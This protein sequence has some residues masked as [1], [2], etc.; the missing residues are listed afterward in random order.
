MTDAL[1]DELL[2]PLHGQFASARAAYQAYLGEGRTFFH[3]RR[4]KRINLSTRALLAEKGDMLPESLQ[5][6]AAALIEHYDV[7]LTLWDELADRTRPAPGDRFVFENK[8]TY[9]REAE[10]RLER[11]YEALRGTGA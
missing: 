10:Q 1:L 5:P 9:P 6:C 2:G 7:W 3:A 8:A 4:L 11:L